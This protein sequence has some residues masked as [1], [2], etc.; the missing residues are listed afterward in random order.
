MLHLQYMPNL[1]LSPCSH[2]KFLDILLRVGQN[3]LWVVCNKSR[4][5]DK[6]RDMLPE[7]GFP[8]S[9]RDIP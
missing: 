1:L 3:N 2:L 6:L 4:F 8:S 9:L 5:V 7:Q